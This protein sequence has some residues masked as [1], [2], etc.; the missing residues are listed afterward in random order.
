M[1]QVQEDTNKIKVL[2]YGIK[3][4]ETYDIPAMNHNFAFVDAGDIIA[5]TDPSTGDVM[6]GRFYFKDAN[7]IFS[8]SDVIKNLKEGSIPLQDFKASKDPSQAA[9]QA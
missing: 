8:Y 2:V 7:Q 4:H 1:M 3:E 5:S 6:K 9:A